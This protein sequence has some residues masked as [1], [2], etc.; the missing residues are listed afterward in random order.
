LWHVLGGWTSEKQFGKIAT[1][2]VASYVF[3]RGIEK[4]RGSDVSLDPI[5]ASIEAYQTFQNEENKGVGT[6]KAGGRLAGEVLS[7]VPFGQSIAAAYPEYG[8]KVGDMQAPTRKDLFGKGDPTRFGSGLLAIKGLQDPLFKIL[9]PFGGQQL[10]RTI[11]GLKAVKQGF[12]E[13]NSGRVQYPLE[14]TLQNY[15]QAGIFG[16]SSTPEAKDYFNNGRTPLGDNQSD[17]FKNLGNDATGYYQNIM[18]KRVLDNKVAKAS[19][20]TTGSA[21]SVDGL[22]VDEIKAKEEIARAQVKLKGGAIAVGNKIIYNNNGETASI[23]LNPPTKGTGIGAFANQDWNITK[24]REVWNANIPQDQKDQAFKKLGVKSE[25]VRYDALATYS[26]DI[27]TQYLLSKSPDHNT[28]LNNI[29]TGRVESIGGS[30]FAAN[31]VID[32][33]VEQGQL[34]KEEGKALKKIKLD[35]NGNSLN[36]ATGAKK[37]KKITIKA[38][39][40]SSVKTT[41]LKLSKAPKFKIKKTPTFTL[42]KA[43]SPKTLSFKSKKIR[44]KSSSRPTL[45]A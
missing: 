18:K 19:T 21:V 37:A 10:E 12:S 8:F 14:S 3:N 20:L 44:F 32:N 42:K 36:T 31:G 29:M 41:K 38:S 4:V 2:L 22:S 30:L 7:N 13:S 25:D 45:S 23:D 43:K 34:S 28:L 33:L 17:I 16:K 15:L 26:N 40:I 27:K 6:L 24:A 1:F 39:K 35:K 9:P 5:Q 11:E